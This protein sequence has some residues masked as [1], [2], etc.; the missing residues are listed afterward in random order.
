MKILKRFLKGCKF[1]FI[2]ALA[3]FLLLS[4]IGIVKRFV[5]KDAE[6]I[7]TV[8]GLGTAVVLTGS[9]EPTIMGGDVILICRQKAYHKGDVVTFRST[10]VSGIPITHRIVEETETGFIT[11]G[12]ANNAQDLDSLETDRI[13][14]KVILIIPKAGFAIQFLQNPMGIAFLVLALFA[15]IE[16]PIWRERHKEKLSEEAEEERNEE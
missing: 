8:L 12:D 1:L 5:Q 4:A 10:G 6:P 14:G 3:A 11:Q 9:M 7:T 2:G 13:I 16:V 15:A